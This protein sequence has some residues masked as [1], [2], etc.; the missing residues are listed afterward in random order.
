MQDDVLSR[1]KNLLTLELGLYTTLRKMVLREMEAVVLNEDMEELL[2]I[3]QEKQDV[4]SRLQLLADSWTDA[5]PMLE[6]GERRGMEGFWEKLAA[7]FPKEQS[8]ELNVLL[9]ETRAA[10]EEVTEAE[11]RVEAE[12]EKH[13]QQL[14]G[15]MLQMTRGRSALIGYAKMGGGHLDAK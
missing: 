14:R 15:K 5:L 3:L 7:F 13:V 8:A 12:L 11:K 2:A 6:L 9:A 10:G 1:V 4:I